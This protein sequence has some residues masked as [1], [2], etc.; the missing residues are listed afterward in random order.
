MSKFYSDDYFNKV[1]DEVVDCTR[2]KMSK[3][4]LHHGDTSVYEHSIQ[5]AYMSY[6]IALKLGWKKNLHSLIV[7][8][9]LHDYFLYDWHKRENRFHG[10]LHPTRAYKNAREDMTL[11]PISKDI[12]IKHMF[13]LTLIPPIYKESWLVSFSDKVCAVMEVHSSLKKKIQISQ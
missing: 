1:L 3:E 9:L 6:R 11:D 8:G 5:V 13:P 4:H 2:F 10:I 12:I 7:G